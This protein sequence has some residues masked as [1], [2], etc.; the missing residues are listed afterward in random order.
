MATHAHDE[1]LLMHFFH[2]SL[3]GMSLNWY[4]HLESARVRS[5]KDLVDVFLKQY[6]Y[7]I[8]MAPDRMQLQSMA[9]KSTETFKEYAQRWREL[10]T[11]VAPPLQESE[12]ITMFLETLEDPFYKRVLRSVSSNFSDLV[13]IGERVK[14]GLKRGKIV[15][16]PSAVTTVRKPGFNNGNKK[17]EGEVQAASAMPHWEGFQCQY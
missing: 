11:Q 1:K 5:W 14:R 13:T 2:D 3:A 16:N 12:M 4:M 17:K 10:A 8:D 15:Q 9:K 7:N 6:K